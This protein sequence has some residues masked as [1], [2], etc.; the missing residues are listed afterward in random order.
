[1]NSDLKL[2]RCIAVLRRNRLL[3][4][5]GIFAKIAL[6]DL[7]LFFRLLRLLVLNADFTKHDNPHGEPSVFC[8]VGY[9]LW[10]K[11]E[12]RCVPSQ[13]W[14]IDDPDLNPRSEWYCLPG[15]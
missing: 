9:D 12:L 11:L 1:M 15:C 5:L 3:T 8:L 6:S 7:Y 13:S 10:G 14:L 2:D 4:S